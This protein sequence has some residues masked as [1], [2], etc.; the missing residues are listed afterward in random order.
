MFMFMETQSKRFRI[1]L[2]LGC[3]FLYFSVAWGVV[4]GLALFGF[5]SLVLTLLADGCFLALVFVLG[6]GYCRRYLVR[7][8]LGWPMPLS[9]VWG[10]VSTGILGTVLFNFFANVWMLL[11]PDQAFAK[12]SQATF[13]QLSF[14]TAVG[15][16]IL[17]PVCEEFLFRLVL[18]QGLRSFWG[19]IPAMLV[20]SALFGLMHGNVIQAVLLTGMGVCCC[21]WLDRKGFL[22]AVLFHVTFNLVPTIFMAL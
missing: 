3:F 5:S 1:G 14:W 21:L 12:S 20:S 6:V 17:G 9:E 18:Y 2:M 7:L 19:R 15:I 16:S 8:D 13:S 22:A 4:Y 11:A 10:I